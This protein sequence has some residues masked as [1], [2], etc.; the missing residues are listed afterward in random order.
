MGSTNIAP[1]A[2]AWS[3]RLSRIV[4]T[5]GGGV[6]VGHGDAALFGAVTLHPA[7]CQQHGG[8]P[9]QRW[10]TVLSEPL[11]SGLTLAVEP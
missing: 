10:H 5:P 3:R 7:C 2:A 8:Q 9:G 11:L 4:S 1:T 6:A